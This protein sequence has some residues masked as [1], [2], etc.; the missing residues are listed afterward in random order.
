M[1]KK[2]SRIFI[3]LIFG[4]TVVLTNCQSPTVESTAAPTKILYTQTATK[5]EVPPTVVIAPTDTVIPSETMSPTV[6]PSPGKVRVSSIEEILG[7]WFNQRH[8]MYLL[9]TDDSLMHQARSEK[10]LETSPFAVV[11]VQFEGDHMLLTTKSVK[12]V[13][14][15]WEIEGVYDVW[16]LPN[17]NLD[18]ETIED[19]CGGR[20][21]DTSME[22]ESILP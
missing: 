15:C 6:T 14:P 16:L 11:Y 22:Y 21:G 17:G 5:T 2:K 20:A 4:L 10:N 8:R 13:P 12:G 18:I 7:T 19:K 1:A 9:F 3:I